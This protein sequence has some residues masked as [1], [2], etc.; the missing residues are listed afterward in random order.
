[1]TICPCCGFRFEGDL[2][3][4]CE[5]CGARSVG[6]PLPKPEHELPAYGRTLL[7]AVAGTVMVLGFLAQT[8]V[9][10]VKSSPLSLGFW[11]WIAAS[12]TAAWQLK[13]IAIPVTLVVL[14]GGRRIYRLMMRTPT[15]FVGMRIAQRS[16]LASAFVSV[17][18]LTLI[19]VTVPARLRQRQ[20]KIE[21]GVN[22]H[23]YRLARAQMEYQSLHGA[24]VTE[25]RD[26][27]DLPDPDGS[28]AAALNVVDPNGYTPRA[29]VAVV[30]SEKGRPL[31]GAAIRKA[32]VSSPAEDQQAGGMG[33]T[34]YE[35]R[36]AGEDK[37]MNTADDLILRD[38]VIHEAAGLKDAAVPVRTPAR[39]NKR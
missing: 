22:A 32:S 26:L 38:G 33:F 37:I 6:D 31:T 14:L 29:D 11:D 23:L 2:R 5:G 10:M 27:R 8:I 35:L 13:W 19:G 20:M 12:E 39:S 18:M 7:L 3:K 30:P 4:G 16:L 36:L 9:A 34:N 25:L 15:R 17:L 24:V 21:A 28:I 1:M